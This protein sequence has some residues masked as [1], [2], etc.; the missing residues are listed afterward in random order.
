MVSVQMYEV[1]RY[2]YREFCSPLRLGII[3]NPSLLS[4]CFCRPATDISLTDVFPSDM[5]PVEGDERNI[6]QEIDQLAPGEE[7]VRSVGIVP[8]VCSTGILL[9]STRWIGLV[10]AG[11]RVIPRRM[12][13]LCRR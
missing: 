12:I 4:F 9:A 7:I 11:E 3:A 2:A 8:S 6:K 5:L 1:S 13:G 10:H